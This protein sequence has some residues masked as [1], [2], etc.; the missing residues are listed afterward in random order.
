M[1]GRRPSKAVISKV[2]F[3]YNRVLFSIPNTE[4]QVKTPPKHF[5]FEKHALLYIVHVAILPIETGSQFQKIT[6]YF[7]NSP[8]IVV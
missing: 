7:K 4:K 1:K 3:W 8:H 2:F 6:K 5:L